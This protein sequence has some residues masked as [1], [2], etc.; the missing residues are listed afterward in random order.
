MPQTPIRSAACLRITGSSPTRPRPERVCRRRL[1]PWYSARRAIHPQYSDERSIPDPV[2]MNAL[3]A[4]FVAAV[5]LQAALR[6][7]LA[8]RQ[9]GAVSAH[10]DRV[11]PPFDG[12][13]ALAEQQR[14][15]DY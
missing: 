15:A 1:V 5:V 14:A 12:R 9:I 10:R 6:L 11:P 2:A 7:W 8:T 3:S 13:I 4:G